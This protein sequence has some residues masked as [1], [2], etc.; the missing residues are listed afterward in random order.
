MT[1]SVPDKLDRIVA[2][3]RR[4]AEVRDQGYR[5]RALKIYPWICGPLRQGIHARQCARTDRASPRPQPQP[6]PAQ[7]QQL[8]IALPVLP[9]QRASATT[10]S[11]RKRLRRRER[12]TSR[13]PLPLR[14]SQGDAWEAGLGSRNREPS[15]SIWLQ[16]CSFR[17][18]GIPPACRALPAGIPL[19]RREAESRVC[20]DRR[21]AKRNPAVS[22]HSP[23][24]K[25][26]SGL[27][28]ETLGIG[29]SG[30]RDSNSRHLAP[31]ASA[32]PGCATPRTAQFYRTRCMVVNRRTAC[33]VENRAR[34][35]FRQGNAGCIGTKS[36]SRNHDP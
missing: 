28:T 6:Q 24:K 34:Q 4:S 10:G 22:S 2:D 17:T 36:S 18:L 31:K 8:G 21:P 16:P 14:Q 26:G 1:A 23:T 12:R 19:A 5:E 25:K 33:R 20:R 15:R 3:A 29:W 11:H 13:N 27:S 35:G 9:R 32:L 30:W 7:W